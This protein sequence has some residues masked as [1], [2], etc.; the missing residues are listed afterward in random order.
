MQVDQTAS[1]IKSDVLSARVD[2]HTQSSI[3]EDSI[4]F[5]LICKM[6]NARV[7][8]QIL[9]TLLYKKEGQVGHSLNLK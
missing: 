3:D 7:I 6:D 1:Q 5:V 9:S 8:Y 4:E 2:Q